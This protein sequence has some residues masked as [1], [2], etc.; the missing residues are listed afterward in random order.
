MSNSKNHYGYVF[1]KLS[2]AVECLVAGEDDVRSRLRSACAYLFAIK[3]PMLPPELHVKWDL[4]LTMMNKFP[5]QNRK[6]SVEMTLKRI[7]N[8][9]GFLE[10][11]GFV[12]HEL[13][14]FSALFGKRCR[15]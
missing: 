4:I 6:G 7:R 2:Q 11:S 3:K 1:G 14:A 12:A 10:L 9:H 8:C 15:A 13:S 5:A